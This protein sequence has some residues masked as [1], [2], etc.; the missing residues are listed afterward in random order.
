[1]AII[2]LGQARKLLAP[3]VGK[4]GKCP[5]SEETRL[6]IME[7]IQILLHKGANGNLRKWCFM[8]TNSCFTAPHDLDIPIKVMINGYPDSVWSKWF[9]FFE[10]DPYEPCTSYIQGITEEINPFYTIYDIPPC[11]AKIYALALSKEASDAH[12]IIQG[13]DIN[14][15]D[16]YVE[17]KGEMMHGE[18]L[19]I[20]KDTPKRTRTIFKR[21]TGIQKTKTNN[22]IRLYWQTDKEYGLLAEYR[23]SETNPSFRRF[24]VP[25]LDSC[26]PA[27]V[28]IIGRIKDPDYYHDNDVLP[29]TNIAVLRKTAQM[30]QAE[31]TDKIEVANYKRQAIGQLI[32]DENQYRR[33]GEEGFDFIVETSP[34]AN[35]NLI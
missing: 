31:D 28:T 3:Y 20:N 2:T 22:Y 30:I 21:I 12:L 24:R 13:I 10:I 35:C 18:Y 16:V 17:H 27:K 1:M 32:D 9:E 25:N 8:T 7:T 4:S 26:K 23:P 11:G 19:S 6:F 5:D 15:K 34:G 33:N 29:I 14:G